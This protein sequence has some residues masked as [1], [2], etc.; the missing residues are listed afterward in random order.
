VD[1]VEVVDK[2]TVKIILQK[3]VAFYK[4]V[5]AVVTYA[6]VSPKAYPADEVCSDC[7]AG[8]IGPYYIE[9]FIRDQEIVLRAN[10]NYY[11]EKP[12]T[13]V[14]IVK[15]FKDATSLRLA[16]EAGEIDIAWRTLTPS[17]IVDLMKKP[18]FQ[19]IEG[20]GSFIRYI[21][22]N[23]NIPP[24][25]KKL[26]R[27]ALAAALDRKRIADVV[28]LGTMT[29]LYSLVPAGMWSH[30]DAFKDKYGEGPNYEL[31]R[32]LLKKAG[33]SEEHKLKL[34][35]WYTPTHYGDTEADVA[36]L[37]KEC[38]E[39]TGMIEVTVKSAEWSTYIELT[40][41][42]SLPIT[43]YGWYP[44]YIDP[45]N[46]LYPFLHT[47]SNRWLG[48]P[49]SNPEMDK[50]LDAAQVAPSTEERAQ[51]YGEVQKLLA[52]DAPIIPILQGKLYIV[53]KEGIKGI[54]IDPYMLLRYWLIYKE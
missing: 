43:L 11:G 54:V 47:G 44:D 29:P 53:A 7:T 9:S 18:G 46:F 21:V 45:D 32:E 3:P 23:T 5:L 25:N 37:I 8:G 27:Q 10:P 15:F 34:E 24:L 28:F 30:I 14:I 51:L 20:K 36:A 49:Y 41:K 19:V 17:D 2:Y 50:L 22:L 35:L 40:R 42:K 12:K 31:A 6:P 4:A 38:W 48:E 39:K 1:K 16:L 13:D 33:Y 52:E 26:V